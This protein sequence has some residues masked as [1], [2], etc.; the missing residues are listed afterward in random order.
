MSVG[1]SRQPTN[2][3]LVMITF[4]SSRFVRAQIRDM[5]RRHRGEAAQG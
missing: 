4:D 5:T 1:G 3:T 2:R